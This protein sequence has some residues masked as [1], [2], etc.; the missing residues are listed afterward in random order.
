MDT[1]IEQIDKARFI[2]TC[3]MMIHGRTVG[4]TFGIAIGEFFYNKPV[5]T[6]FSVPGNLLSDNCHVE[7]LGKKGFIY[8]SGEEVK[9]IIQKMYINGIDKTKIG[10]HMMIIVQNE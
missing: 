4:E 9:S 1:L 8:K 5:M 6:N 10:R 3:D 7:I 2:Q